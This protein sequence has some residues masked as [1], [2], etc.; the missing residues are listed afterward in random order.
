[1]SHSDTLPLLL[2]SSCSVRSEQFAS[3]VT[4]DQAY[5]CSDAS[6]GRY[7]T[8]AEEKTEEEWYSKIM[9]RTMCMKT[10]TDYTH[11]DNILGAVMR[12]LDTFKR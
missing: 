4:G 1:M 6:A 7:Q 11:S 3:S 8:P 12:L 10:H 5:S 2:S 9:H